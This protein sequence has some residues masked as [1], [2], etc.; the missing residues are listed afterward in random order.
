MLEIS[1]KMCYTIYIGVNTPFIPSNIHYQ[2]YHNFEIK[3][4]FFS[5]KKG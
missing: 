4:I 1:I 5:K 3:S 2:L